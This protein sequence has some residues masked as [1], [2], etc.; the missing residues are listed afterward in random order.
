[1][2][3]S[4]RAER[5][6][7]NYDYHLSIVGKT[8]RQAAP[9]VGADSRV[10]PKDPVGNNIPPSTIN[11]GQTR[12]GRPYRGTWW[13][14]TGVQCTAACK[15]SNHIPQGS[16]LGESRNQT[17]PCRGSTFIMVLPFQG[18]DLS[19]D[20]SPRVLP[21]A[22]RCCPCGALGESSVTSVLSVTSVVAKSSIGD[23]G[24]VAI[25]VTPGLLTW[26]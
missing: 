19:C 4:L 6:I 2:Q 22:M 7:D 12:G 25:S 8:V 14:D 11:N 5:I 18:A 26:G 15:A 20:I 16:A 23:F 1:M 13:A 21:W 24:E 10:C 17:A 3:A 9:R